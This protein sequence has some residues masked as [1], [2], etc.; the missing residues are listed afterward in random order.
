[1][2]TNSSASETDERSETS[3]SFSNMPST[4]RFIFLFTG[5][6]TFCAETALLRPNSSKIKYNNIFFILNHYLPAKYG[7]KTKLCIF[8]LYLHLL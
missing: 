8:F 2:A 1:M 7:R 3:S 5:F 6:E 4:A